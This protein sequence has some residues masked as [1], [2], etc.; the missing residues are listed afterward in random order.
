MHMQYLNC[1]NKYAG[2]GERVVRLLSLKRPGISVSI[3]IE[4]GI[5]RGW[6]RIDRS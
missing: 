4:A 5:S 1:W 3:G 2:G 6:Y